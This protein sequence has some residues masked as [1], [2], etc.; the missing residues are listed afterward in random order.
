M[1]VSCLANV[2]ENDGP[3]RV[4]VEHVNGLITRASLLAL[5]G[6]PGTGGLGGR[7]QWL[8]H[9]SPRRGRRAA[10]R[11]RDPSW[12]AR[13]RPHVD[14]RSPPMKSR[15]DQ[16]MPGMLVAGV[17]CTRQRVSVSSTATVCIRSAHRRSTRRPRTWQRSCSWPGR[18]RGPVGARGNS[19][20]FS[21]HFVTPERSHELRHGV[22]YWLALAYVGVIGADSPSFCSSTGSP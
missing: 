11:G 17:T 16:R 18:L 12:R 20:T 15:S 10:G 7:P 13:S 1:C 4:V 5:D 9:R 14:G 22:G 6:P 8:R 19:S 2:L 3:K 21:A